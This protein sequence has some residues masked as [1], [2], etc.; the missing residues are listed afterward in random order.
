MGTEPAESSGAVATGHRSQAG[1]DNESSRTEAR[2]ENTTFYHLTCP[3]SGP[4]LLVCFV[5]SVLHYSL[6]PQTVCSFNKDSLYFPKGNAEPS[7]AILCLPSVLRVT[8]TGN[9]SLF[10]QL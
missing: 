3:F 9:I 2:E 5:N 4:F 1:K 8:G 6:S 10:S 7:A